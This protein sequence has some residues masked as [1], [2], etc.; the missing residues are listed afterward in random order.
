MLTKDDLQQIGKLLEP[1]KKDLQE[2]KQSQ[3]QTNTALEAVQAGQEDIREKLE[4]K[5]DKVDIQ[6]LKAE[7]VKKIKDHE[8]RIDDLEKEVGLPHPHKH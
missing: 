2:V 4:T 5:A 3:T 8:T 7:V 1:I 6:D